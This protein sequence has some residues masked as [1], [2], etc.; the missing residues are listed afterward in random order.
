MKLDKLNS[1][2]RDKN[3][4]FDEGPHIYYIKGSNDNTSVTTFVH[5][6]LF[7]CFDPDKT[8]DKMMSS[9]NWIKS[10]Y[11]GMDREQIKDQ[12]EVTKKEASE[13]GTK[14]HLDIEL[15][16][17]DMKY[18]N[19]SIEFQ[20]FLKFNNEIIV[21]SN[22]TPFR[23]EW[24]V[25]DEEYKLAGSIDMLYQVDNNP[26]N[27]VIY[28]WKRSKNITDTNDFESGYPPIEHIPNSNFWHYSFQLNIYKY[29][30][31]KNYNKKITDMYL[32]WLHP[33][34]TSFIQMQVPNLHNDVINVLSLRKLKF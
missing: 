9:S 16:Y 5:N 31:E 26:D 34:N 3:I 30:L 7:P 4:V 27:L 2:P 19:S 6:S 29:I 14:M 32:M 13:A 20:Y 18:K 8:I 15:F 11:F 21:P 1:H 25:Y 22:L 23:T 24:V 12:W 33:N 17:N 10:K 28:D